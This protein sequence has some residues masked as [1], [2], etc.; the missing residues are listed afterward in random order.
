MRTTGESLGGLPGWT[1]RTGT[2]GFGP[3]P[4]TFEGV[5]RHPPLG[6]GKPIIPSFP[7]AF[8]AAQA[9]KAVTPFLA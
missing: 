9:T 4:P 2:R 3:R 6:R 1:R 7:K 5:E 8:T